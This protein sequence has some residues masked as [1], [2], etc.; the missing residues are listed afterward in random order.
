MWVALCAP[1]RAA[2]IVDN[3]IAVFRNPAASPRAPRQGSIGAPLRAARCGTGEAGVGSILEQAPGGQNAVDAAEI[4]VRHGLRDDLRAAPG[5][6]WLVSSSALALVFVAVGALLWHLHR[7]DLEEQR[8]GLISDVLWVEQNLHFQLGKVEDV[9]QELGRDSAID[10]VSDDLLGARAGLLMRVNP[11]LVQIAWLD[12]EERAIRAIPAEIGASARGDSGGVASTN[13]AFGFARSLG[14]ASWGQPIRAA[15]KEYYVEVYVPQFRGGRLALMTRGVVSLSLLIQQETPWWYTEKYSLQVVDDGGGVLA[16]KSK[17][18]APASG[19]SYAVAFDPPGAGLMLRAIAYKTE[20]SLLSNLIGAAIVLL[21]LAVASSFW[22]LRRHMLRRYSAE[23]ALLEAH[24]FRKAMEDSLTTG[25]RARDLTG[26]VTYVNPAFCNMV[27][28]SREELVGCTPPMP[29]WP[30]EESE[31]IGWLLGSVLAG[32][33]PREGFEARLMRRNGERFDALIYEAPLI[34]AQGRHTGWMGSVL[35]ISARK[36]AE[37]QLRAQQ[38]RLQST[39]RLVT[40]GELASTLAHELNQPLSAIASYATG[41]VNKLESGSYDTAELAQVLRKLGGQAKHAGEIIRRVH[42]FVRRAEP[43][44]APCDLNALVD[45]ALGLLDA[46]ARRQGVRVQAELA[47]GLPQIFADRV[48]IEQVVVN[49][50]RNAIDAMA[51]TPLEGRL[52]GVTSINGD[53]GVTLSVLDRGSGISAEVAERLYAPF[54]STKEE[55]MGMGLNI[56][57]SIIELHQG[58]LWFEP[59]PEGGTLF[60][61]TLPHGSG[62]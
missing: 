51:G 53:A 29:Y 55:G 38:E 43:K 37:D 1:F 9:L 33:A 15:N 8:V 27:G 2:G 21:T 32:E 46:Q 34:D 57:R 19:L 44:R 6:Y 47:A 26:R 13:E 56:C 31:Q 40:M 52:L 25:L 24:A 49:L 60:H 36:R 12:A 14:K 50:V 10:G 39:A 30:P 4:G 48:M 35:D 59:N 23:A 11:W 41:S 20:T 42:D 7:S 28:W 5:W 58:R 3:R 54:F 18:D 45:D 16:S 17:V 61:F 22:A 62:T